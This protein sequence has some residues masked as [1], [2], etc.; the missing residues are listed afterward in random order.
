[1]N[2]T[3]L[4]ILGFLNRQP[5]SGWDTIEMIK[6][7]MGGF[8]SVTT[9]QVYAELI[10]LS[11]D[12]LIEPVGEVGT[13]NRQVYRITSE[14]LEQFKLEINRPLPNEHVRLPILL[15]MQFGEHIESDRFKEM[16]EVF[17]E[18]HERQLAEYEA[19]AEQN[20][21]RSAHVQSAIRFGIMYEKMVL[22]WL[23]SV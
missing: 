16:R 17:R 11:K 21:D 12:G 23:D 20:K 4:S 14:G 6:R 10:K 9:S 18:E 8:W 2:L 5:M 15:Y 3:A 19:A 13:R 22:E 1:M 7:T